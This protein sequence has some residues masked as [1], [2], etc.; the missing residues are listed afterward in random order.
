[1]KLCIWAGILGLDCYV[2]FNFEFDL[3][4]GDDSTL[5]LKGSFCLVTQVAVLGLVL[6]G[7]H[8]I[9]GLNSAI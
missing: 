1:M 5:Y 9:K 7:P 3:R 4:I 6:L 8:S 2:R